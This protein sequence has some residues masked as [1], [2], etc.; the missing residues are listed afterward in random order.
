MV[1]KVVNEQFWQG[2]RVFITGHTGFK[3]SWLT[4]WLNSL[5][6]KVTGYA[7]LPP[8]SPN[9]FELSDIGLQMN[10]VIGDIRDRELLKQR[11][12]EADPDIIFH[13]AA[14]P[15]VR[16]SYLYPAE[17]Y[18]VNVMGTVNLMEAVRSLAAHGSGRR[19]AII[20][21]TTDK[22]YENK[23]WL[24]GYRENDRLGGHD[25]YSNSK[26]CSELVTAAYR[27][28]F[29]SPE[30]VDQHG[31]SIATTRAG[32]VIGGGDWAE[33]RLVPDCIR[34]ILTGAMMKVRN[35]LAT[36][37]W[38]H[39]LDPLSGYL[40]LAERMMGDGQ[41]YA[42]SWNFGPNDGQSRTVGWIVETIA[43]SWGGEPFYRLE[44]KDEFHE[45]IQLRLDCSKAHAELNW[46]P[47]W[48]VETALD[49]V[50]EWVRAYRDGQDVLTT[51]LKQLETYNVSD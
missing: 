44:A 11:V 38:Q 3:G 12:E 10:S 23:E 21:I 7:C 9:L 28:S 5:G 2:K 41:R 45:A 40:M 1:N 8:T 49:K 27:S 31:V 51:C 20:N 37:P 19:R 15:L 14:E 25:P 26:A 35:P 13:L 34:A 22:C 16:R 36:R 47:K 30:L 46:Y 33:D 4:I 43:S 17:T 29:F 18:E 50:L 42:S 48:R 6:A 24:W 32:N 39:V